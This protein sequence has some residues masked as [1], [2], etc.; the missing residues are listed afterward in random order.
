MPSVP[1][2][3]NIIVATGNIQTIGVLLPVTVNDLLS[4]SDTR[5]EF[6]A[7]RPHD[8]QTELSDRRTATLP[9]ELRLH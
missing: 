8:I 3:R 9:A 7:V 2:P 4:S 5:S 1:L 6:D